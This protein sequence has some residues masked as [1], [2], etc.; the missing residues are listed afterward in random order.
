M[1]MHSIFTR[2]AADNGL[3]L[4]DLLSDCRSCELSWSRQDGMLE[5]INLGFTT[6]EIAWFLHRDYS[7][8]R[9]GIDAARARSGRA[10]EHPQEQVEIVTDLDWIRSVAAR[11]AAGG[12]LPRDTLLQ[13]GASVKSMIDREKIYGSKSVNV[14]DAA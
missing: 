9:Y 8:I 11:V 6:K 7:T 4:D 12:K 3:T 13:F 5:C 14:V 2:I 10:V 1:T